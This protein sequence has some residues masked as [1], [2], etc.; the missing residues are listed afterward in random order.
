MPN[1]P[2]P[3]W[4]TPAAAQGY[5]ELA[6]QASRA[7]LSAQLERE[8]MSQKAAEFSV[9]AQQRSQE[10]AAAN[11]ARQEQLNAEHQMEQQKIAI[12]QAYKQQQVAL[13]AADL[14]LSQKQFQAKTEDAAKKFTAN[15]AF[16]KA[17]LPKD[18]GGEGLTPTQAALKY[19]SPTM[20]G[21]EVG[22]LAAMPADFKPGNTFAIPNSNEGLVQA[23]PNRWEK[24]ASIPQTLTNAPPAIPQKDADGNTIGNIVQ[25]PGNKPIFEKTATTSGSDLAALVKKRQEAQGKTGKESTAVDSKNERKAM[26]GYK[27]GLVYKGGLK[28]LGGDPNDESSWEKVK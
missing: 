27:I 16:Q 17:M 23:G 2:L 13:Q 18:Q 26:G 20:T 3:P 24:Y 4:L 22:R 6:G 28:Y 25:I 11:A 10:T 21:T 15:Q 19:I 8:Q 12:E 9:E 7:A 14:D 1:Y 5:G